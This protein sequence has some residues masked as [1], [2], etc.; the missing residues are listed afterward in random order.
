MK[1]QMLKAVTMFSQSTLLCLCSA[2]T[3][4]ISCSPACLARSPLP[5]RSGHLCTPHHL[6]KGTTLPERPQWSLCTLCLLAE[7]AVRFFMDA[8][9]YCLLIFCCRSYKSLKIMTA[10]P[11]CLLSLADEGS[12]PSVGPPRSHTGRP[13]LKS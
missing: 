11:F 4:C 2:T 13:K 5:P 8:I 6:Q 1:Q 7:E 3:L 10:F 12:E 9:Q